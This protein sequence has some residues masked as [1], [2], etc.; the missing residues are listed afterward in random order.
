MKK[1][2]LLR[3]PSGT[4][5]TTV[6][7]A[8]IERESMGR[9]ELAYE[10]DWYEADMFHMKRNGTYAFDFERLSNAHKW[11]QLSTE[12]AMFQETDLV[13]VSNTSTTRKECEPYIGLAH[14]FGYEVEI[15]RTPGPW[16]VDLMNERNTHGVPRDVLEKQLARYAPFPEETEWSDMSVFA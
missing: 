14:R 3:G 13:I 1:L 12:K 5:K 9:K 11:C 4:G 8:I 15:V 7:R 6:G 16:D 10:A 2:I